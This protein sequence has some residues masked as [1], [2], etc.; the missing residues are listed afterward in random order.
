MH[1]LDQKLQLEEFAG[2]DLDCIQDNVRK[3]VMEIGIVADDLV[4][5]F[6]CGPSRDWE[7]VVFH[8]G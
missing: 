5:G 7:V 1:E 3:E 8:Y 6:D 2:M 4:L